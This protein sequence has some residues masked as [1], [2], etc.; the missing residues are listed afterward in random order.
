MGLD[1]CFGLC[2]RGD[3][4]AEEIE[5]AGLGGRWSRQNCCRAGVAEADVVSG[6]VGEVVQEGA[7]AVD[8]LAVFGAPADGLATRR[9]RDLCLGEWG[10]ALRGGRGGVVVLEQ[11]R[12][13]VSLHVPDDVVGQNAQEDMGADAMGPAVVDRTD[14]EVARLEVAKAALGMAEARESR[15][16]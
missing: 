7:E 3:F 12:G 13:E 1:E 14:V 15:R 10:R 9:W 2:L 6:Q 16:L 4:E 5:G 8:G 11:H